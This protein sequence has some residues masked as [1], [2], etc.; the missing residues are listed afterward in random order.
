M[1]NNRSVLLLLS[2]GLTI[3]GIGWMLACAGH[4]HYSIDAQLYE[5]RWLLSTVL[6]AGALALV[7]A[8]TQQY[9][10]VLFGSALIVALQYTTASCIVAGVLYAKDILADEHVE[11]SSE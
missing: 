4:Y 8:S 10:S 5:A 2:I 3:D 9:R 6:I 1:T 7:F 11:R